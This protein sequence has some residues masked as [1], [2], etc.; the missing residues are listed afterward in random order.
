MRRFLSLLVVAVTTV[1]SVS[2][3]APASGVT[4]AATGKTVTLVTH[5]SF[6]VSK[7]VLAAFTRK[8]GITVK[9]VQAGDAGAMVNQAVLTKGKPLGD[10]LFGVDT[11]FLGRALDA[12]IFTPYDAVGLDKVP[13]GLQLDPQHR[14]TPIDFGDVCINY[15]TKYFAKNKSVAVPQTLDDLTKPEYRG[16][17]VV[18]NP[19]TSS[20]GLAFLLATVARYG[21][22]WR[23]YWQ[24]LRANDVQ[25]VNGWEEAYN[26]SFTAGGGKGTRPLVV[27]YA[28]SPP[29][30][31]YFSDPRPSKSPVGTLLDSCF[32]QV[33]LAGV[34]DGA[35][36][37]TGARKLVDFMLTKKFQADMPLQMFV[38]PAVTGTPL[39]KVFEDFAEVAPNPL[40][41]T[42]ERINANREQWIDQWTQT[43]L[44]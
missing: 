27:S 6:A 10:V 42:A 16:L 35:A 23:R 9:V 15:D 4:A 18:E 30:A 1:A 19:A 14:V 7:P 13:A 39:P 21:D 20:P 25:V 5:D 17:F 43:V 12:G 24:Q 2:L 29:A 38:F 37:P 36:N 40:S 26:G 8:T 41:M 3:A 31:V 33:E 44:R 32:R 34:L 22:N 28:S 11:T